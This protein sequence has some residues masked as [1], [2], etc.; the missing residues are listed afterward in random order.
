MN[1]LKEFVTQYKQKNITIKES[2]NNEETNTLVILIKKIMR[3]LLDEQFLPSSELKAILNKQIR[4][5]RHPIEIAIVGQFS[6]GKST[7]LNALLSKNILPTGITPVTSKVNFINYSKQYKLKITYYSGAYEYAPIE[8]I[9]KFTDQ[10][11]E[12]LKDIKYLSLFAPVELLKN[13]SLVDTPG[14]NSQSNTDTNITKKILHDVGG[15][16]WLTLIDNAAKQSEIDILEQYSQLYKHK[17]LCVLN[18]KDKF[19]LSQTNTSKKYVKNTLGKYFSNV[20]AVSSKQALEARQNNKSILIAK[21]NNDFLKELKLYIE[22]EDIEKID[23]INNNITQYKNKIKAIKEKNYSK[24]LDLHNESNIQEVIDFI[25]TNIE[26]N[27]KEIKEFAIKNDLK[28]ICNI[29]I[30][31][32]KNIQKVYE[33]LSNILIQNQNDMLKEFDTL[34][35]KFSHELL[36]IH[37]FLNTIYEKI[38]YEIFSNI[39]EKKEFYYIKKQS[40][41]HKNIFEQKEYTSF[42]I[43]TTSINNKLY[44]NISKMFSKLLRD[45]KYIQINS[46]NELMNLFTSLTNQINTWQTS[47]ELIKKQRNISS[48]LEF[49]NTRHFAAKTFENILKDYYDLFNNCIQKINTQHTSINTSITTSHIH[50]IN[51]TLIYFQDKID[52]SNILYKQESIKHS[53]YTPSEDEILDKIKEVFQ[54]DDLELLLL[55]K[56]NYLFKIIQL[57]KKDY[58]ETHQNKINFLQKQYDIY[59]NKIDTLKKI[60]NSI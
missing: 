41:F 25:Q 1:I 30:S 23:Y 11:K 57:T 9:S 15:I 36:S 51:A 5:S 42:Y 49:S 19:T 59:T 27:A 10:R 53:I 24:N 47:Y 17:A 29:L 4:K 6:S 60:Y 39:E 7:F 58:L 14:L 22:N 44:K 16:I 32:Y 33:S 43:N 12:E 45:F 21:Q 46:A 55:S 48:N 54:N 34:S 8:E 18:Q 37:S 50:K 38:S 35:E 2:F 56:R 40:F 20:I 13:I 3:E 31:D 28:N 26:P 52:E